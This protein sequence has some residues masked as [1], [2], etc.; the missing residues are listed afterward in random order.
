V[1]E[2]TPQAGVWVGKGGTSAAQT[3]V[4]SLAR[5]SR[6]LHAIPTFATYDHEGKVRYSAQ[7]KG[8]SINITV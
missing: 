4:Y 2:L 3:A 5:E 8:L 7:D 6:A 1:I